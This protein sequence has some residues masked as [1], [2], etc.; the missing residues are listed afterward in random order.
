[1]VDR[2]ATGSGVLRTRTCGDDP[3]EIVNKSLALMHGYERGGIVGVV[4]HYPGLGGTEVDPHVDFGLVEVADGEVFEALIGKVSGVMVTH[5]GI[6]E[7]ELPCS[8]SRKCLAELIS[9]RKRNSEFLIWSDA[10]EMG[11]VT[12][13]LSDEE[14]AVMAVLAGVDVLVY[15][16]DAPVE[17]VESVHTVLVEQYLNDELFAERVDEVVER[18]LEFKGY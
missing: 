18:G 6:G 14:A 16:T 5:V 15:G 10:M 13:R 8:V 17:L 12:S 1:V 2:V 4:K 11:A 7:D 9:L 3:E